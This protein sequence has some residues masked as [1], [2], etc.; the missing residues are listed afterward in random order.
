MPHPRLPLRLPLAVLADHELQVGVAGAALAADPAV[1]ELGEVALEETNLV[2]AAHA[3][4]V[5]VGPADAEVVPHLAAV[6]GRRGLRDQLD[7]AH[8]LF[9]PTNVSNVCLVRVP[10]EREKK[11]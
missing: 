6:D 7:A 2:L 1:L 9:S 3:R 10:V 4:R 8:V 11:D 5:G